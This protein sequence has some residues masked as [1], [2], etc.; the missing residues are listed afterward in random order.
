LGKTPFRGVEQ[1]VS[2]Q[3]RDKNALQPGRREGSLRG[4]YPVRRGKRR[5]VGQGHKSLPKEKCKRFKNLDFQ[6]K[7][8]VE[9]GSYGRGALASNGRKNS[10]SDR[11]GGEGK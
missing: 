9:A 8:G 2:L 7:E 4:G 11:G 10:C 3:H 1:A 6:T 5:A